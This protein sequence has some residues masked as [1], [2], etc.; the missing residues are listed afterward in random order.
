MLGDVCAQRRG[1]F[2]QCLAQPGG[3]HVQQHLDHRRAAGGAQ[4]E[5]VVDEMRG[6]HVLGK[7]R[8]VE[9]VGAELPV[10]DLLGGEERRRGFH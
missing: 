7:S 10:E 5:D 1:E 3:R 6:L 4:G 8:P 9:Q 2:G